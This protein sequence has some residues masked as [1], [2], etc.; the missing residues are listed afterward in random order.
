MS[1]LSHL[2]NPI[3]PMYHVI[4][5]F[6]QLFRMK[7]LHQSILGWSLIFRLKVISKVGGEILLRLRILN[8]VWILVPAAE[9][10]G[11]P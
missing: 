7:A 9:G 4:C 2:H 8:S 1:L 5:P 10:K 11:L 6:L 3:I